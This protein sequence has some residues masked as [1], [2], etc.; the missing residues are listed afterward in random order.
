MQP[1][2]QHAEH[3]WLQQFVGEWSY[4]NECYMGPDESMMVVTGTEVVRSLGGIWTVGES[5]HG[6]M[7]LG[8]DPRIRRFV[9]SFV[10]SMMTHFWTY[11]GILD[12]ARQVLTLDTV[13]PSFTGEG[14]LVKYQDIVTYVDNEHKTLESRVQKPDGEWHQFMTAKYTRTK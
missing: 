6:T 1:P 2:A 14:E 9:G 8:Y 11:D 13:G 10:A 7:T 4:V 5:E 12:D 3:Q